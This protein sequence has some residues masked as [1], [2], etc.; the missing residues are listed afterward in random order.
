[1]DVSEIKRILYDFYRISGI[2]VAL[3]DSNFHAIASV[4]SP[5][6]HYCREIHNSSKCLNICRE[7][8][9]SHFRMVKKSKEPLTY[10]CPFGFFTAIYPIMKSNDVA[11]YLAFAPCVEK[12][13]RCESIPYHKAIEELPNMNKENLKEYIRAIPHYTKDEISSYLSVFS[14][15]AKELERKGID[16]TEQSIAELI[17]EYIDHNFHHKITLG[18]ISYNLHYSTVTLT[19]HFKKEYKTSIMQ[20]VLKK[21]M[22]LAKELLKN[23]NNS[24]TKVSLEC[25]FSDIEYFSRTFKNETGSSPTK[26][27]EENN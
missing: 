27:R 1:M 7:A 2:E 5:N 11:G 9:I 21:R 22:D 25:G 20:Y 23:K 13:S 3:F 4:K 19:E 8:D 15:I 17:K 14:L 12:G 16:N 24:I 10:T 18:E 6:N 26:W